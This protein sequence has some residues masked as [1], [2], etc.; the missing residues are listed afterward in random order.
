VTTRRNSSIPILAVQPDSIPAELKAEHRWV[1]WDL[2]KRDDKCTKVPYQASRP[3]QKADATNPETWG[4]FE[5]ALSAYEDGKVDGIGFVLGDGFF[6]FDADSCRDPETGVI[7]SEV[8]VLIA[9]LN[10]YTEVSPRGA[11]VKAIRP[12]PE[13]W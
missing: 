2:E 4:D 11:G 13:T 8:A 10:T 12:G 3:S 6:G 5:T 1:L 7:A 9:L